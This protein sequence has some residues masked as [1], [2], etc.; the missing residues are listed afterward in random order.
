MADS[1]QSEA[2]RNRR[3]PWRL[4]EQRLTLLSWSAPLL[5]QLIMLT[6]MCVQRQWMYAA[7][8]AP[9]MLGSALMLATMV[10]RAK[11][12]E[13]SGDNGDFDI[14]TTS[15]R[16]NQTSPAFAFEDLARA[17]FEE[18]H[19]LHAEILPW[20][21]IVRNWMASPP[22]SAIGVSEYGTFRINLT[23]LGPH[24]MVAGTTGSG[25]SE[26]LISWCMALA[27]QHSPRTLH[28]VFL[29]FKG[30]S[31]F[32]AL[33]HLPHTVGNVCDL[34]LAHA[35]RA[36]NAIEQEL[37]RR[38]ALVSAE[39]VARF[40]QL[41]HPPARL[42]VVIDEFHALRD[43]LPDYMQRLNR[44]ASLGRSLGMHLIVCTQNPMGQ[45]H[46]DMKANIS[47]NICLR[48]TDQ[49]QS[50]ELIG[51]K[52]A[53]LIPA[54]F[55][56]A[57]YCHDGQH[58]TPFLCSA[59]HDIDALVKAVNTAAKFDGIDNPKPL[60]SDPLS[61]QASIRDLTVPSDNIWQ[62]VPFALGDDGV[63]VSTAFLDV[64]QGN[65]AI[66][67][68]YGSGKTNLMLHCASWLYGTGRCGIRFTRR[69]DA[70][71]VT[72]DG[73]AS[74][75]HERV[76]WFVDDADAMLDPFSQSEEADELRQALADPSITVIAAVEQPRSVLLD[77]C[78]TRIVFPSGE[79]SN[80]L[81]LGVPGPI[82]DGFGVDDYA[83][84][85]RGAFIQQAKAYPV[86]CVEFTGF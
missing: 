2:M 77:R 14:G 44:L 75:K 72:D 22:N 12:A 30:G 71:S 62:R 32:N 85:G 37:I 40:D 78:L 3:H 79:R 17:S 51:V 41:S 59:V 19:G 69:T 43:R 9:G 18:L 73:R 13:S 35:V 26:L 86:Q 28:F 38:E 82:L 50:N 58:T 61:K 63:L 27:I 31:T 5:A 84:P 36:L 83:I 4:N 68:A 80:D 60:F 1:I 49:M 21:A 6:I 53:A 74:P 46:A 11:H 23:A 25:K 24:A 65:I 42:V 57:A 81:M 33:E 47:L 34:D 54:A 15:C 52:D 70:G 16:Q 20:R 67:G 66:I 10:I 48:V 45:V 76:I 64:G 8:L 39:R 7:M 29:D 55:P 56:G